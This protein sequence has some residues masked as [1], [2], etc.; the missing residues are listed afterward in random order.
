MLVAAIVVAAGQFSYAR[1]AAGVGIFFDLPGGMSDSG[2]MPM[3]RLVLG[4]GFFAAHLDI[5]F[6]LATLAIPN[7]GLRFLPYFTLNIPIAFTKS[8]I[9]TPY[10]GFA[11]I[12]FTTSALAVPPLADSLFKFGTS[13]TF[14][15]F[16]FFAE[17]G[18]FL[19]VAPL[20]SFAVGFQLDFGSM[21]EIFCEH[22]CHGSDD[23]YY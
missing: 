3:T 11:P 17:V 14:A 4:D 16:G 23:D 18:F 1:D 21:S 8:A 13:F 2:V 6:G 10:A 19:P 22:D 20:P 15:G 12:L 7:P 5:L 9:L